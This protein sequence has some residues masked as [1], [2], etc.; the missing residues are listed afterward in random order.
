MITIFIEVFSFSQS[1]NPLIYS[2]NVAGATFRLPFEQLFQYGNASTHQAEIRR[3]QNERIY[4]RE[5][6]LS[7]QEDVLVEH[8]LDAALLLLQGV[9]LLLGGGLGGAG[10]LRIAIRLGGLIFIALHGQGIRVQLD[11]GAQV[12]QRVLLERPDA[13][14]ALHLTDDSLDLA[15]VDD[16]ADIGIGDLD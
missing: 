12:L 10:R 15:A 2:L 13:L 4:E 5:A 9:D 14:L 1:G 7:C 3:T 8:L 11:H 6:E 16:T